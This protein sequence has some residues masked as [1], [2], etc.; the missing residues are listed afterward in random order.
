MWVPWCSSQGD[1][2]GGWVISIERNVSEERPDDEGEVLGWI[3]QGN[4]ADG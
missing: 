3:W 4:Q 1:F 2:D